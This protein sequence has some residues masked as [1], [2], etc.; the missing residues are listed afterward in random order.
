MAAPGD[1]WRLVAPDMPGFGYSAT[2]S[3]DDFAYTF[4]ACADFLQSFDDAMQLDR[5]VVW[6]HDCGSQSGSRLALSI[7]ER[8][9]GLIIQNGDIYEDA[10]GPKYDFPKES[11]E[12]PA[13][14]ARRRIAN[15]SPSR[16]Q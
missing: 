16:A 15:T 14:D 10:F 5:Y 13:P 11:W 1:R 4:D 8:I 2:P 9:A 12:N 3:P 7:P 6:L